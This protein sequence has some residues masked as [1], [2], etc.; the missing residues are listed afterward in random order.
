MSLCMCIFSE[1]DLFV[2]HSDC[3]YLFCVCAC[4]SILVSILFS[5]FFLMI[6]RP[7]RSTRTDT[8]FP[9][10]T[11]F[12]SHPCPLAFVLHGL[13]THAQRRKRRPQIMADR[14]QHPVLLI[15][16]G[17]QARAHGVEGRNQAADVARPPLLHWLSGA[18]KR[19]V[20]GRA[21]HIARGAGEPPSHQ[22]ARQPQK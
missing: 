13:C 1:S 10:T 21:R 11:L 14:T 18:R 7:P 19:G 4:S 3:C 8:L 20:F 15:Q 2:I 16:H 5:F 12:R 9:Y 17:E 22:E 6:R